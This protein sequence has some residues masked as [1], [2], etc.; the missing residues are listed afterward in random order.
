M[1]SEYHKSDIIID[2][3][4]SHFFLQIIILLAK[5]INDLYVPYLSS[6]NIKM[7]TYLLG[8]Y[9][10]NWNTNPDGFSYHIHKL[11]NSDN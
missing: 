4:K 10:N 2:F 5:E 8:G 7:Y 9:T 6:Y 3:L 11:W 1:R